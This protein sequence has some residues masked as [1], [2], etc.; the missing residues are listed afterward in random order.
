MKEC[1]KELSS[2]SISHYFC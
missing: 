2:P 1:V